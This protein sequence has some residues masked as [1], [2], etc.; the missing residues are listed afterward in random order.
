MYK[1]KYTKLA[2]VND[3]TS[4]NIPQGVATAYMDCELEHLEARLRNDLSDERKIK[5]FYPDINN[6]EKID[7]HIVI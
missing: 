7:G 1:I 3:G 2:I 6:I 4:G 5:R